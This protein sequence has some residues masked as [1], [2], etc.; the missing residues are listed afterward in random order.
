MLRAAGGGVVH[1]GADLLQEGKEGAAEAH[2]AEEEEE[3]ALGGGVGRVHGRVQRGGGE[4]VGVV[5]KSL[6]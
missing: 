4:Q 2:A 6:A 3:G 1:L 5:A